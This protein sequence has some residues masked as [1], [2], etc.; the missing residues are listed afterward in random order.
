MVKKTFFFKQAINVGG[1]LDIYTSSNIKNNM[2]QY[3]FY[4]SIIAVRENHTDIEVNI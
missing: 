4:P 2:A 3:F 1:F